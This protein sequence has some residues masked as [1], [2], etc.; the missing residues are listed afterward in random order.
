MVEIDT[1]NGVVSIICHGGYMFGD[2]DLGKTV[3]CLN[4]SNYDLN[5]TVE[6]FG[7]CMGNYM[8]PWQFKSDIFS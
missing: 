6:E 1:V 2:T 8:L 5:T 4:C 3:D 7:S